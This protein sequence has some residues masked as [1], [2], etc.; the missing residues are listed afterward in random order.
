[1]LGFQGAVGQKQTPECDDNIYLGE[2]NDVRLSWT[3]HND[4]GYKE[5]ICE[6]V[7]W[8]AEARRACLKCAAISVH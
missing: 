7:A 2:T 6:K 8:R 3:Y 4:K 1:M 5:H